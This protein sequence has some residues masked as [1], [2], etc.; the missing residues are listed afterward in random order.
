M[1]FNVCSTQFA[2][3]LSESGYIHVLI[4]VSN[5]S[6][7]YLSSSASPAISLHFDSVVCLYADPRLG[8]SWT[9]FVFCTLE[10]LHSDIIELFSRM[11][12]IHD[13]ICL[14]RRG[15]DVPVTLAEGRCLA[16]FSRCLIR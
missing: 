1:R 4:P 2:C 8:A 6:F 7:N 15:R 3:S 11:H 5:E 14:K 10:D 12:M 9:F 16:Y 13:T